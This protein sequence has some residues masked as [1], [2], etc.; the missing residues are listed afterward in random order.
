MDS[1]DSCVDSV[2][3]GAKRSSDDAF[4]SE[5]DGFNSS[6]S[7]A[8]VEPRKKRSKGSEFDMQAF[9][10][11]TREEDKAFRMDLLQGIKDS[12]KMAARAIDQNIKVQSNTESFQNNLL[13]LFGAM[14]Q[15]L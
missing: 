12:N 8:E 11:E 7:E 1:G 2:A 15:K 6:E 4:G 3:A 10:A 9:L 5:E 13:Q 14:V